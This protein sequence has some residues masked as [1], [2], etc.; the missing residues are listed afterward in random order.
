MDFRELLNRNPKVISG[1]AGGLAVIGLGLVVWQARVNSGNVAASDQTYYTIDDGNSWFADD[2]TKV[3]PFDHNGKPAVRCTVYNVN[4]KDTVAFLLKYPDDVRTRMLKD[5]EEQKAHPPKDGTRGGSVSIRYV[6]TGVVK[7]PGDAA[8]LPMAD[9]KAQAM[10]QPPPDG[11][12][13]TPG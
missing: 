8:W 6:N 12:P 7:R 2:A 9:A 3:P 10:M 4:G 5:F 1:I 11:I 13:V